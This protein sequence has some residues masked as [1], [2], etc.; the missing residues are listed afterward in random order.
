MLVRFGYQTHLEI[1][2][3]PNYRPDGFLV[4][5]RRILML[6]PEQNS[7]F[8]FVLR[9]ANRKCE[10]KF[11]LCCGISRAILSGISCRT[12]AAKIQG[13]DDNKPSHPFGD[14]AIKLYFFR[15]LYKIHICRLTQR[16]MCICGPLLNY[17]PPHAT[18][19]PAWVTWGHVGGRP[20]WTG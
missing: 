7:F 19:S 11:N 6:L 9:E 2:P 5:Y 17:E 8:F 1:R 10:P 12:R 4:T 14:Y 20:W 18:W 16:N 15:V 13:A 3:Q